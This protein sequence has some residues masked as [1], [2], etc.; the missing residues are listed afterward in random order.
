[1]WCCRYLLRTEEQATHFQLALLVGKASSQ[2]LKKHRKAEWHE[3]S[4]EFFC[5]LARSFEPIDE[6]QGDSTRNPLA[7]LPSK[8]VNVCASQ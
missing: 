1:M 2:H 7:H 3:C 5:Q 6:E 4:P 8:C